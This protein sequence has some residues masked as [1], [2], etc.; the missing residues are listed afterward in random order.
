MTIGS[1]GVKVSL[2]IWLTFGGLGVPAMGLAGCAWATLIVAYL[3]FGL[4]VWMRGT[5]SMY[6]PYRIWHRLERP[7]GP[8]IGRLARLGIP[9]YFVYDRR[10]QKLYG[11]RLQAGR[12][13]S[14][15]DRRGMLRSAVLGL[16]LAVLD[17]RLRFFADE[18]LVPESGELLAR[19][20][21][22]MEQRTH[23]ISDEIAARE[24]AELRAKAAEG[25]AF[26]AEG[27]AAELE[28]ALA[29]LRARLAERS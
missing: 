14:I 29:E 4:A 28:A 1:L 26:K 7:A 23:E 24:A 12:Y 3:M 5:Q 10:A 9:E 20:E 25:R 22:L 19:L 6:R 15:I 17:G 16:D 11:Y 27:R 13:I 18:A 21:R 8:T 2:S